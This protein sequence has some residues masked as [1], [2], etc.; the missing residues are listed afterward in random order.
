VSCD[1]DEVCNSEVDA[2]FGGAQR[3]DEIAAAN[4]FLN[5]A[6]IDRR[7]LTV[8]SSVGNER[9]EEDPPMRSELPELGT[10]LDGEVAVAA[11]RR[12]AARHAVGTQ[13][14]S[15]RSSLGAGKG[16]AAVVRA[17]NFDGKDESGSQRRWRDWR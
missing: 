12:A 8:G 5:T 2:K 10:C 6:A 13:R 7:G 1:E 11:L 9:N 14:H 3:Y 16:G 15:A 4:S 17:A